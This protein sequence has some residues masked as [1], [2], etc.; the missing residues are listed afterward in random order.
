MHLILAQ[1]DPT[2]G[3]WGEFALKAGLGLLSFMALC[4]GGFRVVQWL[5]AEIKDSRVQFAAELKG[6]RDAFIAAIDKQH[7]DHSA[8][9]HILAQAQ[10]RQ[11]DR[12]IG[13]IGDLGDEMRGYQNGNGR[14]RSSNGGGR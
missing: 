3:G 11:T 5:V 14:D 9:N 6:S 13:A 1:V 10:E 8:E 2:T 12:I 7:A 4:Y